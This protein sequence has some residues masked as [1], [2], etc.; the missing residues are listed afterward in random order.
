M[1]LPQGCHAGSLAF[2]LAWLAA[3]T[4]HG[5]IDPKDTPVRLVRLSEAVV[6]A[7]VVPTGDPMRWVLKARDMV[8]GKASSALSLNLAAC[9]KG[10]PAQFAKLLA[11]NGDAPVILFTTTEN[12]Q[13]R[14]LL[15]VSGRWLSLAAGRKGAWNLDRAVPSLSGVYDGGT[16]MLIRMTLHI[17]SDPKATVPTSVGTAWTGR[18]RLGALRGEV[19]GMAAVEVAG[20]RGVCLFVASAAGDRLYQPRDD[21]DAMDDVTA[22]ARLDTASRRFAWIDW[23]RDGLTDLVTW[24]G[25]TLAVRYATRDGTFVSGGRGSV[26]RLGGECLGLAPLSASADGAPG[27]LV[28]TSGLPLLLAAG[29]RRTALPDGAAVRAVRGRPS[30]CIVADLDNDG[31]GDVLQPRGDGGL[32]WRGK[33]RGFET[34]VRVPLASPGGGARTTLGDL[35]GDGLLDIFLSDRQHNQ[36]WE[37]DGKGGFRPVLDRAGSLGPKAPAGASDCLAT[38]LNHDGRTDLAL[39][40]PDSA[41]LYHFNRGFRCFGEQGDLR[42]VAGSGFTGGPEREGAL[43]CTVGDFNGDGGLDLAAAFV[44]GELYCYYNH[45]CDMPAVVVRLPRGAT[46]PVT[47]SAWQGDRTPF[48]VGTAVVVAHSPPALIAL[49]R[50]GP[51]TLRYHLRGRPEAQRRLTVGERSLDVVVGP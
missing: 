19:T 45:L 48:C 46:G 43:A 51:C 23:N 9:T 42:L 15:H 7:D 32:L 36:L 28:S 47:V 13:K 49:R 3:A 26:L 25:S 11:A 2:C 37:S 17:L 12:R 31:F 50:P 27:V 22:A 1:T 5:F 4:A 18:S 38:D 35:D 8:K 20:R 41:F 29:W 44:G 34:P 21:D 40:Y 10:R 33:A 39:C 16:D 30:A 6:I 14:A 24:D